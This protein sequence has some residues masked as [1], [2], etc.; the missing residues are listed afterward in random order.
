MSEKTVLRR[1][2]LAAPAIVLLAAFAA[3]SLA[4]CGLFGATIF[5][6]ELNLIQAQADVSA[7]VTEDDV[8]TYTIASVDVGT[9]RYVLFYC[10]WNEADYP[11]VVYDG[12]LNPMQALSRSEAPF[13]GS[14]V[15]VDASAPSGRVLIGNA[16]FDVTASGLTFAFHINM[17]STSNPR[18][19]AAFTFADPIAP[20]NVYEVGNFYC[21][22][23]TLT[24][25]FWGPAWN[26]T[27]GPTPSEVVRIDGS[28]GSSMLNY[29]FQGLYSAD[30]FTTLVFTEESAK[31][32]YFVKIP[33]SDFVTNPFAASGGILQY[34]AASTFTRD[35]VRT[36]M[37]GYTAGPGGNAF[38]TFAGSPNSSG[39]DMFRFR[40]STSVLESF[41]YQDFPEAR[42][43]FPLSGDAYYIYDK[44]KRQIRKI[45][46][47]WQ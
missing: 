14:E 7:Y 9:S 30:G 18:W 43:A 28:A 42:A 17:G 31:K 16:L 22:N 35:N 37:L 5:P 1:R 8:D 2:G 44:E 21:N 6:T 10:P 32:T 41:H 13:G 3:V 29:Y 26:W 15:T 33:W 27:D 25:S 40:D 47:W 39:G 11:L 23:M 20:P 19:D 45:D 38:I 4:S 46:S 24:W 12:N 34:Y 36:D